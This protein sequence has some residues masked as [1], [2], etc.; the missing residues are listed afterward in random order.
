M[1]PEMTLARISLPILQFLDGE[2][3]KGK[4]KKEE[5]AIKEKV[6]TDLQPVKTGSHP[7]A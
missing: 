5:L 2:K 4:E 7:S 6:A 1:D 3:E